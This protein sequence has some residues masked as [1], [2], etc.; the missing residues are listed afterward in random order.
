[1]RRLDV[2]LALVLMAC[3][4]VVVNTQHRARKLFIELETLKRE[5]RDLD[6]AWGKLQLEQG[7]LLSPA[8]VETLARHDLGLVSPPLDQ[9][10]ILSPGGRP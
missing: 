3:A 2:M 7:T 9:V 8:R 5:A 10:H 1:M 6:V 4:L